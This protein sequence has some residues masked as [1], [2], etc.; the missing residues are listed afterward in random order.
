MLPKDDIECPL[1]WKWED[2][3]WSTDLNRAVDEQGGNIEP[4]GPSHPLH[5]S[6]TA[7]GPR[8][9][10]GVQWAKSPGKLP[11]RTSASSYQLGPEVLAAQD[12]SVLHKERWLRSD[13]DLLTVTD[14]FYP[15]S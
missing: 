7:E 8:Q 12:L 6:E 13:G 15:T 10:P 3:E 1:G 2:E 14:M 5:A 11:E 4:G 9:M